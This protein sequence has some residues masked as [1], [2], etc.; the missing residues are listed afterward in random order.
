M[1]SY[2]LRTASQGLVFH[3][4]TRHY[5]PLISLFIIFIQFIL[6]LH[7]DLVIL[8]A[9]WF[10]IILENTINGFLKSSFQVIR[11]ILSF[12]FFVGLILFL[13]NGV[14]AAMRIILRILIGALMFS[15]FFSVTNPSELTRALES[16][17]IPS[18]LAIIPALTMTLVPRI[19][20]DAEETIHALVLRDEITGMPF[21]WMPKML[22]ILIASV[23][24]RAEFLSRSLY[25][26]GFNTTKRTHYQRIPLQ[27]RDGLR[28]A[29][30][31]L[32]LGTIILFG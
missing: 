13:F 22:A 32:I 2:L 5:H 1:L 31:M 28:L 20:K 10:L 16:L 26:R 9:I 14:A 6:L 12:I 30:W 27:K 21:Q 18:K 3:P 8:A 29:S 17:R 11:G 4:E 15:F 19:A 25:Y 7:Q 24:Y 23:M